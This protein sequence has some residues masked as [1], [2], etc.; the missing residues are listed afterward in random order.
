MRAEGH[1]IGYATTALPDADPLRYQ[2]SGGGLPAWRTLVRYRVPFGYSLP[3]DVLPRTAR[4]RFIAPRLSR[5]LLLLGVR[6]ADIGN[7]LE[8]A[9]ALIIGFALGYGVREWISRQRHQAE[10]RRRGL[11]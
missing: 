4:P 3:G 6:A 2:V 5:D 11:E 8:I 9:I 7:L 10:R 1:H